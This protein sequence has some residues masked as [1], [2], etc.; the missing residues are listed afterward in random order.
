M[1]IIIRLILFA[2][3]ASIGVSLAAYV[4]TRQ[5]KYLTFAWNTFKFSMLFL[6][7][8][9]LLLILERAIIAI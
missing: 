5:R 1:A 4:F 7:A 2:V 9:A 3:I 8:L 6:L